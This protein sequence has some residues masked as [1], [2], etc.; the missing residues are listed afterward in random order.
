MAKDKIV[1]KRGT[2][3]RVESLDDDDGSAFNI[4]EEDCSPE[5]LLE[6]IMMLH[7]A[8]C[9]KSK[10]DFPGSIVD[11]IERCCRSMLKISRE[12]DMPESKEEEFAN[13]FQ[14]M[15][16]RLRA[17]SRQMNSLHDLEEK[18]AKGAKYSPEV[19]NLRERLQDLELKIGQMLAN[20]VSRDDDEYKKAF[21]EVE[22][23]V[24]ELAV[25]L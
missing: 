23:L 17:R 20:G 21:K 5:D 18:L 15:K 2:M 8:N 11:M 14:G 4:K 6:E 7:L 25:L 9:V 3:I 10:K 12:R 19:L 1:I 13:R 24:D 16:E 22:R